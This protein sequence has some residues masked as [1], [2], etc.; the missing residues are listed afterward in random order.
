MVTLKL[1]T[2]ERITWINVWIKCVYVQFVSFEPK[3][4]YT[5]VFNLCDNYFDISLKF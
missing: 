2:S 5:L 3:K 1:E 4:Y